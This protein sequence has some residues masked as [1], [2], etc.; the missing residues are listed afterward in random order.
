MKGYDSLEALKMEMGPNS[1]TYGSRPLSGMEN[2]YSSTGSYNNF[3][4]LKHDQI[5]F[6]GPVQPDGKYFIYNYGF[7][8]ST[9][10]SVWS[11][12]IIKDDNINNKN[13][14]KG[15]DMRQYRVSMDIYHNVPQ[16][17]NPEE[18]VRLFNSLKPGHYF[19]GGGNCQQLRYDAFIA[20][21]LKPPL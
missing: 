20:L 18:M 2:M 3:L 1:I 8:S 17:N 19:L 7:F 5:F 9:K 11:I 21:G 15:T 16:T 14:A 13:N 10:N 12:G 6:T 4:S